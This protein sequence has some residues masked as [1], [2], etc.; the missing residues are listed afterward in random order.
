[1][2]AT[3]LVGIDPDRFLFFGGELAQLNEQGGAVTTGRSMRRAVRAAL[4]FV[5]G[6]YEKAGYLQQIS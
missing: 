2:P 6:D 3:R 5:E 4:P 1:M